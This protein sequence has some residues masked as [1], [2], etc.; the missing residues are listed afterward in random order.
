MIIDAWITS[1]LRSKVEI[2][3]LIFQPDFSTKESVSEYSG[4]GVGMDVVYNNIKKLGGEISIESKV[5]KG[6][7][8]EIKIPA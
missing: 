2:L 8:F 6:T 4:R 7:K 1:I 5:F 3:K